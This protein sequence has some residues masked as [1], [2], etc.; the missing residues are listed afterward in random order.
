MMYLD[1]YIIFRNL[2]HIVGDCSGIIDTR[3]SENKKKQAQQ[4]Q[5]LQN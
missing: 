2:F 3:W 4:M 1:V 5:H